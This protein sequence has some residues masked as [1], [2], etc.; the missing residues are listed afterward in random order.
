MQALCVVDQ[1]A[2]R[3]GQ[4]SSL[5]VSDIGDDGT[6]ASLLHAFAG[7]G[8]HATHQQDVAIGNDVSNA[9]VAALRRWVEAMPARVSAVRLRVRF[10]GELGVSHF[11][12]RSLATIFPSSMVRTT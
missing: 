9:D 10:V 2:A 6:D 1:L 3:G 11:S 8:A 12:R 5:D 4:G 7:T